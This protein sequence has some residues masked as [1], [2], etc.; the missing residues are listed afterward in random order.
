MSGEGLE[1]MPA[2][3]QKG[4]GRSRRRSSPSWSHGDVVLVSQS[5]SVWAVSDLHRQRPFDGGH[6]DVRR[7]WS[8]AGRPVPVNTTTGQ[9]TLVHRHLDQGHAH[10]YRRL[11][12]RRQLHPHSEVDPAVN[13]AP[14]PHDLCRLGP[15]SIGHTVTFTDTVC[16]APPSTGPS[17]PP[18]G[19]VNFTDGGFLLGGASLSPRRRCPLQP[20]AAQLV[21]SAPRNTQNYGDIQRTPTTWQRPQSTCPRW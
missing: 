5:M 17:A 14:G 4:T 19:T 7:G 20:G 3:R 18:T 10:R 21:Q 12:R 8:P 15:V 1:K 2:R 9:A 6:G 11:Q 16:P 13:K